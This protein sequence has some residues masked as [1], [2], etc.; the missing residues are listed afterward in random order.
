MNLSIFYDV[1][2]GLLTVLGAGL[3]G[4]LAAKK[5]WHRWFFW[6]SGLVIVVLIYFHARSHK[7]PPTAGEIA[8]AVRQKLGQQ[9]DVPASSPPPSLEKT[10]PKSKSPP[11]PQESKANNGPAIDNQTPI[12]AHLTVTQ[13]YR[14]SSRPDAPVE[15]EVVIQTDQT[16]PSLKLVLQCDKPLVDAQ[17]TLGGTE[18]VV[19][20]AVSRGLVQGHPNVVL[21]SYGLSTPPFGWNWKGSSYPP[22]WVVVHES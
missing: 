17:M 20:M 10:K 11:K 21:Y 22:C 9:Q 6:G 7:E 2:I 12:H 15:A 19:Q 3:A 1:S 13:S 16:Y 14:I 5:W 8:D 18:G 4:H